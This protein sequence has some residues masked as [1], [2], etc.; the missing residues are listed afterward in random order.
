MTPL[1]ISQDLASFVPCRGTSQ[2]TRLCIDQAIGAPLKVKR[3]Q[4]WPGV[5]REHVVNSVPLN[6][7]AKLTP[8]HLICYGNMVAVGGLS[9][10][11]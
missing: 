2:M 5:T 10:E 9:Y 6:V 11:H 3:G 1:I 4:V 7:W 8:Q